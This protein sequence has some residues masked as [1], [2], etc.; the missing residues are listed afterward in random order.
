VLA[1]KQDPA[2]ASLY[3]A[4]AWDYVQDHPRE[5]VANTFWK[6]LRTWDWRLEDAAVETPLKQAAYTVPY[7]L[8]VGL[9]VVGLLDT[10][11]QGRRGTVAFL[12]GGM[13]SAA[14]PGIVT[15][16][17]IRVRMY[18]EFLLL[19]L[20]ALG[21]EGMIRRLRDRTRLPEPRAGGSGLSSPREGSRGRPRPAPP[22]GTGPC[23]RAS[24]R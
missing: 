9:A 19:I 11:R 2:F 20:A 10:L 21:I 6:A 13:L 15:T 3:R 22:G 17:L 16:P 14:L 1:R 24:R 7:L 12:V 4:R 8:A 5:T 23:R 18:T